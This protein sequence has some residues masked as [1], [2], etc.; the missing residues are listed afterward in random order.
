MESIVLKQYKEKDGAA[1]SEIWNQVVEEGLYFPGD[2]VLPVEEANAY[3]LEQTDTITAWRG[4]E[5]VGLYILHPNNIGRCG[6]IAN[7]SCAPGRART[8]HWTQARGGFAAAG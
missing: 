6:H 8:G 1:A 2:R 4:D 7:A 5:M 3:F